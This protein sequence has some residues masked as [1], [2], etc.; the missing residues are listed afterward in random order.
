MG[1]YVRRLVG[2]LRPHV[3]QLVVTGSEPEP[4]GGVSFLPLPARGGRLGRYYLDPLRAAPFVRRAAPAVVH[5]HGDDWALG[6]STPVLRTFY[7]SSL[8]EALSSERLPRK[9]NHLV[10]AGLEWVS[11]RRA[12]ASVAIAEESRRR[13]RAAE[14][15]PPLVIAPAVRATKTEQPTVVFVGALHTRK[16][17]WLAAQVAEQLRGEIPGLTFTVIGPEV[18]RSAY[19]PWVDFRAGLSDAEVASAIAGAWVLLAPSTYEGFGIPLVE[20]MAAGTAVV[21]TPNAGSREVLGDGRAGLL[22]PDDQIA[23]AVRTLLL[24]PADRQGFEE[25]G[26]QRAQELLRAADPQHYLAWYRRLARG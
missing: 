2:E 20:A 21:A 14:I 13:F 16:R 11:A 19:A 17:G 25:K 8:S 24:S 18:E 6:G 7:G 22:V 1:R 5:A 12:T 9:V 4:L 3:D 23:G 10:L 26:R 15:I